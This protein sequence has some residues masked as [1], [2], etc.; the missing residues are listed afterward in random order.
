MMLGCN[1]IYGFEAKT[2]GCPVSITTLFRMA[3]AQES[4]R[5]KRAMPCVSNL[6]K[7]DNR[8]SLER[9][10]REIATDYAR[11]EFELRLLR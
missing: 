10:K 8:A 3:L 9:A 7:G 5:G 4:R 1:K 2:E 6:E 11:G